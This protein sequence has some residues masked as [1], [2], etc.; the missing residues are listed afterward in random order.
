VQIRLHFKQK[1]KQITNL[2]FLAGV[3]RPESRHWPT[4]M[5][6]FRRRESRNKEKPPPEKKAIEVELESTELE[7]WKKGSPPGV[8]KPDADER[9]Q[10]PK[11]LLKRVKYEPTEEL[12]DEEEMNKKKKRKEIK[13]EPMV[14]EPDECFE[15][16]AKKKLA[17]GQPRSGP[18]PCRLVSCWTLLSVAKNANKI[19]NP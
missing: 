19:L 5:F 18:L 11:L 4:V 14:E 17:N 16:S 1:F 3:T 8:E 15:P 9:R 6:L 7:M 2:Q 12:V 13:V 10:T